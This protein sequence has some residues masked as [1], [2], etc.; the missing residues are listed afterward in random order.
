M[1]K[2]SKALEKSLPEEDEFSFEAV[3]SGKEQQEYSP[4]Q[5][6]VTP[7]SGDIF[8]GNADISLKDQKWDE[9]LRL[10][11][12]STSPVAES[13]RRL[14]T[15]ILHPPSGNPPKTIL[16]TSVMPG[17]GKGFVCANL[18]AALAQGIE[19]HALLVDCDLRRP[20]LAGLFGL[21]N[22]SGLVNHLRDDADLALLI[23]KTGMDK[24][25]LVPAGTPPDNPSELLDSLKMVQVI[26][27]LASRY[28]DRFILLDS[29][30]NIVASETAILAQHVDAVIL[31]VRW[32]YSGREQVKK[33]VE[34]LGPEKII[35]VV[36]NA[37]AE[38]EVDYF[39]RKKGRYG[40]YNRYY[41][42]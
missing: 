18:G 4:E 34:T 26:D 12:K 9:R 41:Q 32:G 1:G 13:F 22:D 29:P 40:Y 33:L 6:P 16:V 37:F 39:L 17:E 14:R 7:S 15:K 36:F 30:P 11:V 31:V 24:L 5:K 19:H 20:S 25:S 35:G 2:L 10:T 38:S 28:N 21:S 23:R 8:S 42:G 27:E 3:D